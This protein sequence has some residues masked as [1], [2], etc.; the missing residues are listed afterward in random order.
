MKPIMEYAREMHDRLKANYD[1]YQN[2]EK[3]ADEELANTYQLFQ[4]IKQERIDK[5]YDCVLAVTGPRGVGK[6]NFSIYGSMIESVLL[7]I[8]FSLQNNIIYHYD[9]HEA[10]KKIVNSRTMPY[11]FDEGVDMAFSQEAMQKIN[12]FFGKVIL[13]GRKLNNIYF[14]NMP[15]MWLFS[16]LFTSD[17]I[18]LR[19]EML[20]RFEDHAVAA[21]MVPDKNPLNRDPWFM[22]EDRT[23]YKK[24]RMARTFGTVR[25]LV[26]KHPTFICYLKIPR[27][28][29]VIENEYLESSYKALGMLEEEAKAIQVNNITAQTPKTPHGADISG[30]SVA[31]A[32]V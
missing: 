20:K 24:R 25:D 8:D 23:Y 10:T 13:K 19:V 22:Q 26:E 5:K 1:A 7:G 21:L 14:I 18:H 3:D 16:G 32:S 4:D 31:T 30:H 28:P 2:Q 17:I 11:T 27:L 6:S 12:R 15:R 29:K 9:M